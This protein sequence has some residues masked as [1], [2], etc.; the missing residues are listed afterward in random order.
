MADPFWE[1]APLY[2]AADVLVRPSPIPARPGL[3]GWFFREIPTGIDAS[4]AFKRDGL[5]LLYV[6]ISPKAQNLYTRIRYHY[7]GNAEGSTLRL[8]LGCLL[9]R[10]LGIELRRVGS[11]TRMTFS[12]GEALLREW[13][14]SSALVA[15]LEHEQPWLSEPDI[16]GVLDLPLNIEHNAHNPQR[17]FVRDTRAAC[18]ARARSMPVLPR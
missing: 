14:A 3:Y 16:I 15:V 10:R 18:K 13:M 6:G 17:Q 12:S 7:T 1:H 8:T 4:V 5:A 11:G 9:E 2:T